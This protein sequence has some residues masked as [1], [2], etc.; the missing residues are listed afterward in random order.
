MVVGF[1]ASQPCDT[2]KIRKKKCMI[3]APFHEI[4][5]VILMNLTLV[6]YIAPTITLSGHL[7]EINFGKNSHLSVVKNSDL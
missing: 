1:N 2:L 4:V 5:I 7:T 6:H 3:N